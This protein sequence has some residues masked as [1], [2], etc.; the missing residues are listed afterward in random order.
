MIKNIREAERDTIPL[1]RRGEVSDIVNMTAALADGA[2]WLTGVII[3]VDGGVS[4]S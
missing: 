2:S 1:K 3:P 4:I